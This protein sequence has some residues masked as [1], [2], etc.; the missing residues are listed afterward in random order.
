MKSI[1]VV[2]AGFLL[3]FLIPLFMLSAC[4]NSGTS[5]EGPDTDTTLG[6][7]SGNTPG[8]ASVSDRTPAGGHVSN[9]TFEWPAEEAA[10]SYRLIVLDHLGDRF[11]EQVTAEQANCQTTCRYQP[12]IQMH[13]SILKWRTQSFD[14]D[15]QWLRTSDDV[16][17]NTLRSLSAQ[18]YT[19][20]DTIGAPP[21]PGQG[22]PTIQSGNLIVL[23]NNWNAGAMNNDSWSQTVSVDKYSSDN[24][25]VTFDYDWL[26]RNSGDEY[27]VKSYPQIVYG[28]K[29]G[30]HV[31]GSFEQT[32]LPATIT[33]LDNF[34][35]DYRFTETGTA[36]RNLAFESFF[37][38]DCDIRGPNFD[39]DNRAYEM[40][41]WIANPSIRTPGSIKA[42]SGVMID[43]QLW[44]LWIK[45]AQDKHYIAYTA[46]NELTQ[47]TLNWNR[48]VDYTVQW[49]A[50]NHE[51]Y[52]MEK[53]DPEYCMSA[54]EF[55]VE[56]FWG[57]A[58]LEI[59]EFTVRRSTRNE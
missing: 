48:F 23:N 45:P 57:A 5:T 33:A 44:D 6:E 39:I 35:I 27:Q 31:S 32:G 8:N 49:T 12:T 41:V 51:R 46:I 52:N 15:G 30:A 19:D 3:P 50:A 1:L 20:L 21:N 4:G 11:S 58:I 47:A 22:W 16:A 54:I 53:L 9:P 26:D 7:H 17:F 29:L 24:T 55:G 18:P 34:N 56:T 59:E 28:S 2:P 40:M 38:T 37:H 13:D 36:E 42:E 10:A 25:T 14:S 43:N